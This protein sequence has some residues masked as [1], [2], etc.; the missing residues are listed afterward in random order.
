MC[1][2][3][4]CNSED[5]T[6]SDIIPFALTG[7][8]I[9]K[10]FVC[11]DHNA[12]TNEHFEKF[13]INQLDWFRSSLG[14]TT[15]D[16][17][18][19][20]YKAD[21]IIKDIT[22]PN[23]VLSNK[24]SFYTNKTRLFSAE[25]NGKAIKFGP[26]E[27]LQQIKGAKPESVELNDITEKYSFSLKELITSSYMLHT[28]AKIA[29]EWHCYINN[30]E[31]FDKEKFQGIVSY[32]VEEENDDIFVENVIDGH[33]FYALDQ[34]C[35]FG[36]NSLFE[37]IDRDGYCYVIFSLWNVVCYK[38]K[39]YHTGGPNLNSNHLLQM[40]LYNI[41]GTQTSTYFGIYGNAHI[42]SESSE[43]A[44]IRLERFYLDRF[45]ALIKTK[46]LSI[47]LVKQLITSMQ[48][49]LLSYKEKRIDFSAFLDYEDN[50]RITAIRLTQLFQSNKAIYNKDLSFNQN[51]SI[52]LNTPEVFTIMI[53]ENLEYIKML[54]DMNENDILIPI[55]EEGIAAFEDIWKD[56]Q[57]KSE[58]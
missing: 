52:F 28:V 2:C 36:T 19:I 34:L 47:Y 11:K 5:L 43:S 56:E 16:G 3:I 39:I 22:I 48:E 14:L 38:V 26:L 6:S 23:V 1:Q 55:L 45:T 54:S 53:D 40:F 46:V 50:N 57:Q 15:R 4:Y 25:Q 24:K 10:K 8:K 27:K 37:Y 33:T 29:Y 21:L 51:L 17:N 49:D 42:S 41:D 35:E 20:K 30:I 18:P 32:I 13:V 12:Y 7:A 58:S 9:K 44:F 31:E